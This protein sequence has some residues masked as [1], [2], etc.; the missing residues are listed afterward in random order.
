M[1]TTAI[2]EVTNIERNTG[3]V[4]A[5]KASAAKSNTKSVQKS[6]TKTT[7]VEPVS[8]DKPT[9]FVVTEEVTTVVIE[10]KPQE[11]APVEGEASTKKDETAEPTE[12]VQLG[13]RS[14]NEEQREAEEKEETAEPEVGK[15]V[16]GDETAEPTETKETAPEPTTTET[17]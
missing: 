2:T 3:N 10:E 11:A 1:E 8:E 6:V 15:K 5:S 4:S 17:N 7:V 14:A 9:E 16:K 13:K 12:E